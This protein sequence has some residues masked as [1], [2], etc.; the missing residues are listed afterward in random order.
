LR[1][2]LNGRSFFSDRR[3]YPVSMHGKS[4]AF[5]EGGV[6]K[7]GHY[8]KPLKRHNSRLGESSSD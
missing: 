7:S 3:I 1:P 6:P 2:A 5:W 4:G 8:R